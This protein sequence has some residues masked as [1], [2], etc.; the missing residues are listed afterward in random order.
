MIDS[1]KGHERPPHESKQ[2]LTNEY[3]PLTKHGSLINQMQM[4]KRKLTEAM[5]IN[6]KAKQTGIEAM[7]AI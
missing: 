5:P 7:L 1:Q 6:V 3:N 2:E 4:N